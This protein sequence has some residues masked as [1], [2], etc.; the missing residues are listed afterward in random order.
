M[1]HLDA[2]HRRLVEPLQV[3]VR[4]PRRRP[5]RRRRARQ[6]DH[7]HHHHQPPHAAT[8]A[9]GGH[10]RLS[11]PHAAT[12]PSSNRTSLHT[13]PPPFLFTDELTSPPVTAPP[14][15]EGRFEKFETMRGVQ[16][17]EQQQQWMGGCWILGRLVVFRYS[18]SS[19]E[20]PSGQ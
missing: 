20:D 3:P 10:V 7:R 19:H 6:A 9:R 8:A 4:P 12:A 17:Q 15:P 14:Q 1:T 11:P 18:S 2:L 5:R 16:Q 13:P